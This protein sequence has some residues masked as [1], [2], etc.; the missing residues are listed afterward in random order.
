[1]HDTANKPVHLPGSTSTA[2]KLCFDK[3]EFMKVRNLVKK[4]MPHLSRFLQTG[5]FFGGRIPTQESQCS[6]SGAAAG[7]PGALPKGIA[8]G[9]DRPD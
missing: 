6:Q 1:M 4:I 7:Q 5:K 2:E 9:D 3:N 8:G